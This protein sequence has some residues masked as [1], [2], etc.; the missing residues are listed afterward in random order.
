VIISFALFVCGSFLL[1]RSIREFSTPRYFGELRDVLANKAE[2]VRMKHSL[3]IIYY[4]H[5][6]TDA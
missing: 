6:A 1:S 3:Q 4:E 5:I 2:S